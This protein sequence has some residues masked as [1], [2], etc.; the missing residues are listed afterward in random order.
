MIAIRM[1]G[2]ELAEKLRAQI[3]DEVE[4][5]GGPVC[6]ATVLVGDDPASHIYVTAKHAAAVE[7]GMVSMDRRLPASASP[8]EVEAVVRELNLDP[9]VDG[10][11]VQLPLPAGLD[12][13][14]LVELVAPD[15]DADGLHPLNLGRL[16]LGRPTVTPATPAGIFR[17]L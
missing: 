4:A 1:D 3:A 12:T 10:I 14:R 17:I 9:L 6:L 5:F 8:A 11:I 7:A 2:K 16:V 13:D 15:K